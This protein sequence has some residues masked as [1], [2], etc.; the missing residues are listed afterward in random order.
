MKARSHARSRG[1]LD[2]SGLGL[3]RKR[4][5]RREGNSQLCNDTWKEDKN[6]PKASASELCS[7]R[8]RNE[9]REEGR[10]GRSELTI[11]EGSS[12]LPACDC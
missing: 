5:T 1:R 8:E 6:E 9:P 4:E 2:R 11:S 3:A 7:S 10:E 12:K